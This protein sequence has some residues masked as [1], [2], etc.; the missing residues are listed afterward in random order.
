M[1]EIVHSLLSNVCN[2]MMLKKWNKHEE[3]LTLTVSL[4][5]PLSIRITKTEIWIREPK[6]QRIVTVTVLVERRTDARSNML[7]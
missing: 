5:Y 7:V 3:I 4:S 2:M 1:P 6:L